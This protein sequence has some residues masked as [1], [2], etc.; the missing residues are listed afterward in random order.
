M[1]ALRVLL[2]LSQLIV[3]TLQVLYVHVPFTGQQVDCDSEV[4]AVPQV[5]L[6][7]AEQ[8]LVVRVRVA[9]PQVALQL[10][11]AL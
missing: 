10:F 11:Q 9:G 7:V 3:H 5:P 4:M 1:S 2:E 8:L 6:Q